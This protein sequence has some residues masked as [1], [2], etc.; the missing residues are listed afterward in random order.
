MKYKFQLFIIELAI[1]IVFY[2]SLLIFIAVMFELG[3]AITI[4][5]FYLIYHITKPL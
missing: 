1:S 3:A 5:L 4:A 2:T